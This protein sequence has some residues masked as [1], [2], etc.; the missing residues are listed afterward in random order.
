M[1]I[2]GGEKIFYIVFALLIGGENKFCPLRTFKLVILTLD[3]KHLD[4][5]KE[6]VIGTN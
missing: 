6:T 1:Q 5:D 3:A 4:M 2:K